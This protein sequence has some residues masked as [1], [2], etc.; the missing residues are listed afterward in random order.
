MVSTEPG[1]VL[2]VK[3]EFILTFGCDGGC[4]STSWAANRTLQPYSSSI[5]SC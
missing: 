4:Q 1:M 5:I 3:T 2:F